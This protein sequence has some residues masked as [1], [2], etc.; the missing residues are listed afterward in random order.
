[1]LE[2]AILLRALQFAAQHAHHVA[3]R[4]VFNQDHEFLAEIYSKMD[5]DYDS[6]IER[7]I[8]LNSAEALDEQAVLAAAVQKCATYPV[9]AAKENKEL[10]IACIAAI[11]EINAKIEMLCKAPGVTQGSVQMMGDFADKNEILLYKLKQRVK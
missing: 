9:K 7:F 3:A 11:K 4:A 6:T 1:M 2:L 10:F 8:G 5:S